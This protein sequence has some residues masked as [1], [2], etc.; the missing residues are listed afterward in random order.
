[1]KRWAGTLYVVM[2]S[3]ERLRG[4]GDGKTEISIDQSLRGS[5]SM[6]SG[7]DDDEGNGNSDTV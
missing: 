5:K 4:T 6:Q 7:H 2:R 1:M 3:R